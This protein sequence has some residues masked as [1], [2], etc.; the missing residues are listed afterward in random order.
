[1]KSD[2]KRL[3]DYI[4]LVDVRNKDMAVNR[5]LGININKEFMPSV[6]NVSQTDLSRYKVIKKGL[7]ACNVMHVGRDERIPIAFY[8]DEDPAIISPAYVMFE[9]KDNELIPEFLMMNFQRSEFDRYAGYICDS[10][11]RGGLEWGRFCE[12]EIPIPG[13]EIQESIVA[14]HHTLETRK[15]LN[16]QLKSQIQK[17]CPILMRGVVENMA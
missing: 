1:M 15:R 17:L 6:A 14:I 8:T 4:Q 13:I 10:S 11:I 5:L 16:I 12:I 2:Y 7:F 3:G 9:I